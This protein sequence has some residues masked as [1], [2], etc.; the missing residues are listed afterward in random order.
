VE[1]AE[2]QGLQGLEDLQGLQGPVEAR[3]LQ[4]RA[5][6]QEL[7]VQLDHKVRRDRRD[8]LDLPAHRVYKDRSDHKDL[9]DHKVETDLRE[10]LEQAV[11]LVLQERQELLE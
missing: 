9:K 7:Q 10:Q 8:R 2:P 11:P 3:V 6:R 4:E 5:G 1:R